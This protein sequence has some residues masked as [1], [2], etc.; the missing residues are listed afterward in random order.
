MDSDARHG[1]DWRIAIVSIFGF[2]L[3]Y[4]VLV[5]LRANLLEFPAQGE[6]ALRRGFVSAF[7][8]AITILLWQALRLL[9]RKP[10]WVRIAA[11]T[12]FAVPCAIAIAAF[13]YYAFN[14]YDQLSLIEVEMSKPPGHTKPSL[15][16]EIADFGLTRYF[17]LIAWASLYLALGFAADVRAAERKAASFAQAAQSAELRALR[18]QVNPHFLFNT[19]NSLSAL[20]MKGKEQ[21]AERM[22]MNLSNFYRSSLSDDPSEDVRLTDEMNLQRLYLDIEAVRFPERLTVK[23]DLPESLEDAAVPGLILQP[24]VENAIKHGVSRTAK[25][26]IVALAARAEDDRLILSVTDTGPGV[27]SALDDE[28]HGIGLS[29]VRERLAARFGRA[30]RIHCGNGAAGGYGVRLTLPLIRHG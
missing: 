3:F 1:L 28:C 10:L 12:L 30:A 20:V 17:F 15:V 23:I 6:M 18:Y 13:N 8:I 22:I 16:M 19:L 7:G 9:D 29:N 14:I 2:W 5:T 24:L 21:E 11:A 27:S 25:P 4:A 26:V